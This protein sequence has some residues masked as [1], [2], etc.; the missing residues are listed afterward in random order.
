MLDLHSHILPGVD[1]G[2]ATLEESL[3]VAEFCARDGITHVIATPHCH[4][5]IRTLRMDILPRVAEFN[6]ALAEAEIPL[7]V[8]PGS[9]IQA[10][11]TELYRREYDAGI[12]CHLGDG[13]TFTLLEFSW[14]ARKYPRDAAELVAW[15]RER[16]RTAIIAHP[17]RY[18]H[19]RDEPKKLQA[20]VDE[21]AWLQLT[22]DSFLG[23]H[24]AMA[25]EMA[26]EQLAKYKDVLLATDT[27]GMQRCSGLS[28]GYQCVRQHFG[29]EREAELR[30]RAAGVLAKLLG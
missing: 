15:L 27:H 14:D 24:G 5:R 17:E 25:L 1:D 20:L 13:E 22:A 26:V 8:L 2:P 10:Y 3:A 12:Y 4:R 9:E 29:A 16:G 21:G 18:K 7:T 11:D 23:N 6:A 19:F 30:D 28:A